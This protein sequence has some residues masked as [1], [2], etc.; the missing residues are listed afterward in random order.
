L[1]AVNSSPSWS[2]V[3]ALRSPKRALDFMIGY[4]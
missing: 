1:S 4:S 2:S 3:M